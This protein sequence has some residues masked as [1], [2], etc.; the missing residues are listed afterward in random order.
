[1]KKYLENQVAI[2][3]KKILKI[4][5]KILTKILLNYK[6]SNLNSHNYRLKYLKFNEKINLNNNK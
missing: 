6:K 4:K 5:N 1:M 3:P 2:I